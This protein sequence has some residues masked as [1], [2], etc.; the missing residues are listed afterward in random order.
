MQDGNWTFAQDL[1]G[2]GGHVIDDGMSPEQHADDSVMSQMSD[3]IVPMDELQS[4]MASVVNVT[5]S[6][7]IPGHIQ[8]LREMDWSELIDQLLMVHAAFAL[9][10]GG[11]G[12]LCP[13]LY[14]P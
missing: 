4:M 7:D 10:A 2:L 8:H 6:F 9:V 11:L 5:V 14:H 1:P 3:Y 13:Q 12:I